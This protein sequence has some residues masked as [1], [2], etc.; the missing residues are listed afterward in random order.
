VKSFPKRP[1][2][3]QD[4]VKSFRE[5]PEPFHHPRKCFRE[6]TKR[7]LRPAPSPPTEGGEGWGEE[8]LWT[9]K[10]MCDTSQAV[11]VLLCLSCESRAEVEAMAAQAVA[12][13]HGRVENQGC[14]EE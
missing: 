12:A 3:F 11:E 2:R 9:H 1:K 7:W 13:G 4:A 5:H 10:P 6:P 8:G 14:S